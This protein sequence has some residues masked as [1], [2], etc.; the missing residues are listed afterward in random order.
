MRAI[1]NFIKKILPSRLLQLL[2]CLKNHSLRSFILLAKNPY[3]A[4]HGHLNLNQVKLIVQI[5]KMVNPRNV[6]EIGF[7]TGRSASTVLVN[8]K[9]DKFISI[10]LDLDYGGLGGREI[11]DILQR[12]FS[13]FTVVIGTSQEVLTKD[14]FI[15]EFRNGVDYAFIDGGHSYE[16]CMSDLINVYPHMN[17]EGVILVDDYMSDKPDGVRYDTVTKA[18]DDFARDH[19]VYK[20]RWFKRGKGCAL[21]YK[22]A[23]LSDDF[24]KIDGV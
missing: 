18:V 3:W 19:D 21:L 1:I 2:R 22:D 12:K 15:S 17:L 13:N 11:A 8:S 9:P 24:K 20:L 16:E 23:Q 10:E 5:L 4:K 6:L 7:A 14:F